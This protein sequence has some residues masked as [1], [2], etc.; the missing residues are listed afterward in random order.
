MVVGHRDLDLEN[1]LI[2]GRS[3]AA[4][5]DWEFMAFELEF[6]DTLYF[7]MPANQEI[8]G[9][10]LGEVNEMGFEGYSEQ[11]LWTEHL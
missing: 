7:S 3:I 10:D 4:I 5:T 6:V 11:L 2:H 1:I 8:W 9:E